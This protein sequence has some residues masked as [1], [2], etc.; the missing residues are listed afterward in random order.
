MARTNTLDDG[1]LEQLRA[2]LGT[3]LATHPNPA[4]AKVATFIQGSFEIFELPLA[5]IAPAA[6]NP[7]GMAEY[8]RRTN[9]WHHQLVQHGVAVASAESGPSSSFHGDWTIHSVV[10]S[11]LASK[12]AKAIE[13]I[14]RERPH[15]DLDAIYC[16]IPAYKTVCFLLRGYSSEEIFVISSSSNIPGAGEGKFY[17]VPDFLKA[18]LQREPIKGLLLT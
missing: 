9:R 2:H 10:A 5:H 3:F 6:D 17:K 11:P 13:M 12:V 4:F 18:L 1:S 15:E 14:D 16:I 7:R 8:L